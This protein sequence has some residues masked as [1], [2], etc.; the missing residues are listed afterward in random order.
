VDLRSSNLP[1]ALTALCTS[2]VATEPLT[3]EWH[4]LFGSYHV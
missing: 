4:Y 2:P 3:M 1:R